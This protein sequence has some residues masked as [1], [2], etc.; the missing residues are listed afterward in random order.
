MEHADLL[1]T[2]AQ[3]S[4][5]TLGFTG[6]VVALKQSLSKWDDYEKIWF[7]ALITTTITALVGSLLPQIISIGSNDSNF[8]WRLSNLGIGIMHVSNLGAI[9]YKAKKNNIK[10]KFGSIKD[11]I[12]IVIGPILIVL[13]FLGALGYISWIQL[14]LVIGVCQQ[15][16]IG[17]SNFLVFISGKKLA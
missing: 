3:I 16:Y 4:L 15:L 5:G 13:H 14:L 2:L 8:V 12:D 7:Q 10:V 9:I 11:M 1:N 6:V 17:I